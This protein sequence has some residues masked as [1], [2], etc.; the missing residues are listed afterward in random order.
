MAREERAGLSVMTALAFGVVIISAI[1]RLGHLHERRRWERK[2]PGLASLLKKLKCGGSVTRYSMKVTGSRL[3]A[4][5]SCSL[6]STSVPG[7][8][9]IWC[10]LHT[11]CSTV[12]VCDKSQYSIISLPK[13]YHVRERSHCKKRSEHPDRHS[14]RTSVADVDT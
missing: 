11:V 6:A 8:L 3:G 14:Q 9:V 7:A 4:S 12:D 10:G 1:R 2:M 5:E 13:G